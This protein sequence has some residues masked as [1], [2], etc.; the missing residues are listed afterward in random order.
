MA[1]EL[2]HS[3]EA[4]SSRIQVLPPEV[5]NRI[6]AGEVIERPAS[7]V[8]ELVENAVDAGARH[9]EVL[10]EGGGIDRIQV[11]DDGRGI[12]PEQLADA[13]ERHATSKLRSAEELFA[14]GT[15]GFRGEALAAVAAAA[16]VDLVTRPTAQ[17][18]AASVRLRGGRLV[19]QGSAAAGEGTRIDVRDLFASLPARRRFLR[20]ARAEA[21]AAV[22][23]VAE[24]ALAYPTIAFR[25]TA[26]GRV[27]LDAPGAIEGVPDAT[28]LREAMAAVHGRAFADPLVEVPPLL[29]WD[30]EGEARVEVEGLISPPHLHRAHRRYLH[31]IANGRAIRAREL[32]FAVER[33]FEG[34]L[35]A[36]R[37]PGGVLRLAVPPEQVDVNVHPTKAEVRFRHERAVFSAVTR[38]VAAA[39]DGASTP[40]AP[41]FPGV[42]ALETSETP[43]AAR[44]R[45]LTEAGA[46][47]GVPFE[48]TPDAQA[49]PNGGAELPLAERLPALRSLGQFDST[50]L[51]AESPDGLVLVDQHAAHE[52]VL[53]ERFAAARE[54]RVVAAQPLLET[55]V[56]D[57]GGPLAALVDEQR[58]VLADLGWS[59]DAAD[60]G[61]VLLR[62][63]PVALERRDPAR[64]LQEYL[65][66]LLA[67]ERLTGPD[68]AVAT[69]ACRAAVMA[70]DRLD[71]EQQRALLRDLEDCAAP[72]T[73]PHGRPTTLHLSSDQLERSF[74]RR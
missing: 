47:A 22:R 65:D 41:A 50:Y 39:L 9:V 57:L 11:H 62:A 27:A 26:D 49:T 58:E 28:A 54:A 3:L 61:A 71:A 2:R 55:V 74:G 14:I 35:P 56:V 23:V 6:A 30:D 29:W 68:R 19:R 60:G 43:E 73:C 12:P 32:T 52:R 45:V 13:F 34:R 51:V 42:E 69:L 44:R 20:S 16:D 64:A 37:H 59:I 33:A 8:K 17:G 24:L 48:A 15:L 31:L 4:A 5:A 46:P 66:Q 38:A 36:G 70:G 72:H 40:Q 7:V 53:Y 67:E 1:T 63:V 21:T 18:A 25:V 10:L